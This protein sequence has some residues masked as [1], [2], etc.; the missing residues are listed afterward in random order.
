[1]AFPA[2]PTEP[3]PQPEENERGI[4]KEGRIHVQMQW[5]LMALGRA[6]GCGVWVPANDRNLS[7][8][9][10][11]FSDLAMSRL[12]NFGFDENT[13]RTIQNIDVLWLAKNVIRKAFEIEATT[14]VYSGLLRFSDLVLAQPN[15]QIDLY[16]AAAGNRRDRV[17]NQLIRPTF[18]TLLETCRFLPFESIEEGVSQID[19]LPKS[20]RVSGLIQGEK[21][22]LPDDFDYPAN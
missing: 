19:G 13:R 22:D 3:V 15:N 17:Y 21:F 7:Y 6:E 1:M 8:K 4:E 10:Q 5:S 11:A 20:A 18:H 12:P 9:G 2:N 16:I 14:S